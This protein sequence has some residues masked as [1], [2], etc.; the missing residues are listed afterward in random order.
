MYKFEHNP[1]RNIDQYDIYDTDLCMTVGYVRIK[2]KS[3]YISLELYPVIS[4]SIIWD[5][6]LY[7]KYIRGDDVT[8]QEKDYFFEKCAKKL[9]TYIE[10]NYMNYKQSVDL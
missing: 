2:K 3:N 1:G 9:D 4:Y 8:Q 6:M 5:N 10:N 7:H